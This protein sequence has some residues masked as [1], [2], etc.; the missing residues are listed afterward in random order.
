VAGVPTCRLMA[1]R[2]RQ[3][4][5]VRYAWLVGGAATASRWRY[6][7]EAAAQRL[8]GRQ[9]TVAL[10]T[11]GALESEGEERGGAATARVLAAWLAG[12]GY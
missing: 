1:V 4:L 6:L 7:I 9:G 12:T 10:V 2:G 5:V 8:W 11:V 3:R